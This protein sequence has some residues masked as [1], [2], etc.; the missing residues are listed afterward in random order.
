VAEALAAG[1][2]ALVTDQTPWRDLAGRHAGWCEAW[3]DWRRVLPTVLAEP[4]E[5]LRAR[6]RA[7]RDWVAAEFTWRRS[8]D[9]LLEFYAHLR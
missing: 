1:V 6:G 9:R 2:P 3:P 5:A 4:P 8:A 7:G